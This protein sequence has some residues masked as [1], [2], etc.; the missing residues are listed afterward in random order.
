MVDKRIAELARRLQALFS[1]DDR[2]ESDHE[3]I[4]RLNHMIGVAQQPV[5]GEKAELMQSA[6]EAAGEHAWKMAEH[7]ELS[8]VL[9]FL[10]NAAAASKAGGST[11]SEFLEVISERLPEAKQSV[12]VLEK[13]GLWPW[14]GV[15]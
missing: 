10:A 13:E 14:K 11:V 2:S 1:Q 3:E 5:E 4:K 7:K 9:C 12:S 6:V 15:N 8:D